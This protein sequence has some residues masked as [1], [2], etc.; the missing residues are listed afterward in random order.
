MQDIITHSTDCGSPERTLI[1]PY[2]DGPKKAECSRRLQ[3]K[4][5]TRAWAAQIVRLCSRGAI[6]RIIVVIAPFACQIVSSTAFELSARA[7]TATR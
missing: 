5:H 6:A 4:C 7:Q 1:F 3:R 2:R